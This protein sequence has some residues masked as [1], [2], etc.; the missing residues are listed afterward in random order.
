MPPS[1]PPVRS[2]FAR[3]RAA[4]AVGAA[5]LL[6]AWGVGQLARDATWITGLCFYIPSVV[7]AAVL[8]L[9]ALLY[10][11]TGRRRMALLAAGGALPAVAFVGLIE[12]HAGRL[13][14]DGTGRFRVVHWNTAGRPARSGVGE[15]LL[16]ERADLYVLTDAVNAAHVGA[17][18][19]RLGAEYRAATFANLA[20]VGRGHLRAEGWLVDRDGFEVQAVTWVP[21]G[22]P[23]ALLVLDLPSSVWA[24]RDPLLREVNALIERHR[25]D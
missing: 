24:A 2:L 21:D 1:L 16:A 25:P 18:R 7:V 17:L 12:N 9:V 23:I 22:S 15:H 5:C 19:D 13:P 8:V 4:A 11:A 20:V 14:A 10:A 3:G 6:S